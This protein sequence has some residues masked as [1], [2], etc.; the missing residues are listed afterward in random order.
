MSR[1]NCL[2]R[3]V[4]LLSCSLALF[5]LAPVAAIAT[6]RASDPLLAQVLFKP[7]GDGEPDDTASGASRPNLRLCPEDA[8]APSK[9]L[10][11]LRPQ[12]SSVP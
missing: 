9:P 8:E 2:I 12:I 5:P 1:P 3:S 4:V 7:P 6:P 10:M 11:V